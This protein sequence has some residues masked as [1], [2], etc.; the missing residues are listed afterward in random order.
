[1]GFPGPTISGHQS[2]GLLLAVSAWQ[3]QITLPLL[4]SEVWKTMC[5]FSSTPPA[6]S[7]ISLMISDL[8]IL[9]FSYY[10]ELFFFAKKRPMLRKK[11]S[12]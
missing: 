5:A 9:S 4:Q 1:M 3:I 11:V 10:A 6:S 8:F 7:G 12:A 2:S